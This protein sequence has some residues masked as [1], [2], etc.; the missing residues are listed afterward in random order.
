VLLQYRKS[1]KYKSVHEYLGNFQLFL[2][3]QCRRR[4]DKDSICVAARGRTIF[5]CLEKGVC[6]VIRCIIL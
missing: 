4:N 3:P 6:L 1:K 2:Y 5:K